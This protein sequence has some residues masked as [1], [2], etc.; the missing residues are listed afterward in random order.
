[1]TTN[2]LLHPLRLA[3]KLGLEHTTSTLKLTPEKLLEAIDRSKFTDLEETDIYQKPRDVCFMVE[4][5]QEVLNCLLDARKR[6]L[7]LGLYELDTDYGTGTSREQ[8][9]QIR[10]RT[11]VSEALEDDEETDCDP[12]YFPPD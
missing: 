8:E 6:L 1:M 3:I 11:K 5:L 10:A 2:D 12:A 4:N 9:I 7:L